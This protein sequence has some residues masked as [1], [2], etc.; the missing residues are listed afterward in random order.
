MLSGGIFW[1]YLASPLATVDSNDS[2]LPSA[3]GAGGQETLL[4]SA[5]DA[6]LASS[7]A[8]HEETG[9]ALILA[10]TETAA[11]ATAP[12]PNAFGELQKEL[13]A[14]PGTGSDQVMTPMTQQPKA[15]KK[16]GK[17]GRK[18]KATRSASKTTGQRPAKTAG[19]VSE[20]D[21]NII[22]AIVR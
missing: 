9:S 13:D 18:K 17:D 7:A 2:T 4:A 16:A 5:A 11:V 8:Y 1:L 21:I 20:R 22:S 6:P 3:H 10:A 15:V 14:L 19:T 12:S